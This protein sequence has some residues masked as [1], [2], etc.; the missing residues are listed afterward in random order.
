[1]LVS[2]RSCHRNHASSHCLLLT[3]SCS[4]LACSNGFYTIH[5]IHVSFLNF[6]MVFVPKNVIRLVF[7][8]PSRYRVEVRGMPNGLISRTST[9]FYNFFKWIIL[10]KMLKELFLHIQVKLWS[11]HGRFLELRVALVQGPGLPLLHEPPLHPPLQL[12]IVYLYLVLD[13]PLNHTANTLIRWIF[14]HYWIGLPCCCSIYPTRYN[15][16]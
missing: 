10:F 6:V 12:E 15:P 1:M 9:T 4:V 5:V 13:N 2:I 11:W 7:S 3:P 8:D 16:T 14:G